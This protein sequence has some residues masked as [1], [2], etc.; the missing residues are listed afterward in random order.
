MSPIRL[1]LLQIFEFAIRLT[2]AGIAIGLDKNTARELACYTT[3]GSVA[4]LLDDNKDK[5]TKEFIEKMDKI[6]EV[7]WK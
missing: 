7:N 4:L 6:L 1:N 2:Q 3:S 5:E